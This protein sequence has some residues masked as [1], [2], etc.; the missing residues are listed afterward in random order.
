MVSAEKA[1]F[2]PFGLADDAV[3]FPWRNDKFYPMALPD[4]GLLFLSAPAWL[5]ARKIYGVFR[6]ELVEKLRL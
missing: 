6:F 3:L 4:D 2:H 1:V 5:C